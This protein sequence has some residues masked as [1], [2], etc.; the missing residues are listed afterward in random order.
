MHDIGANLTRV[1]ERIAAAAARS[2]RPADDIRLIAVSKSHPAE[3]IAAAVRAGQHVFGESTTQEALNKIPALGRLGDARA[4][5]WHFVG[6]LQSN[7]TRFVPGHFHWLHALDSL[8]LAERLSRLT[9]ERG[10]RLDALI[11]VN[12]TADPHKHGVAAQALPP[13][14]EQLLQAGLP[15]IAL[16]GLMTVGPYPATETEARAAF[17][18]L[19]ALHEQCRRQ[20]G[21]EQFT[22]LSM[23]MSGDF[24]SAIL[25]GATMVR[26]GTA[27]FGERTYL[28]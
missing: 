11:E 16:R 23:G 7:K 25:E 4:I 10:V 9:Q 21:I 26:V 5:E 28:P 2:G 18:A 3:A 19:R 20:F 15:G 6:H 14:L 24:E 8:K 12:V 22:E 17:A 27:I 13:L 1:R